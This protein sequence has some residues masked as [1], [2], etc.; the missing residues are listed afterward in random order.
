MEPDEITAKLVEKK[1]AMGWKNKDIAK[2]SGV[3]EGT[4]RRLLVGENISYY[5][6]QD[7][8]FG[9]GIEIKII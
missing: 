7:I 8:L 6:F 5:K 3:S 9:M 1:K 4:I 2:I